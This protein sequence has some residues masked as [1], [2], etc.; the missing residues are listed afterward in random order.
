MPGVDVQLYAPNGDFRLIRDGINA[1]TTA[2]ALIY[3]AGPD[4]VGAQHGPVSDGGS[5]RVANGSGRAVG[6][7]RPG[8]L[9]VNLDALLRRAPTAAGEDEEELLVGELEF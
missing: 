4:G 6:A 7:L 1:Y 3:K 8:Q 2:L 5:G 9:T